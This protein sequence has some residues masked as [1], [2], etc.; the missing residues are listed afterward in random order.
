MRGK[1][2]AF[3]PKG[4]EDQWF[5]H[6]LG[7][8]A[9]DGYGA[10]NR[11]ICEAVKEKWYDEH[12]GR[13]PYAGKPKRGKHDEP[14]KH[15][16]VPLS[17]MEH[18]RYV[19]ERKWGTTNAEALRIISDYAWVGMLFQRY[20]PYEVAAFSDYIFNCALDPQEK[21]RFRARY[22]AMGEE[23]WSMLAQ[24]G[25]IHHN[26]RTDPNRTP[27]LDTFTV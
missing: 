20:S 8:I 6:A 25:V 19:Q 21:A 17:F 18:V 11:F 1:L 23:E 2:Y 3:R 15:L 10:V 13:D 27:S 16:A 14:T 9:K 26:R 4:A 7:I 5:R 24:W 12:G 22:P